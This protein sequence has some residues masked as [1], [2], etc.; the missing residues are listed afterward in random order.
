MWTDNHTAKDFVNFSGVADTVSEII[1]QAQGKPVSIGISGA[2]GMGK[3]SMVEL[4]R[5]SLQTRCEATGVEGKS[6]IVVDFN[7]WLYQGYDDAKAALI[8]VVATRLHEEAETRKTGLDK[9]KELLKRVKWL[10]VGKLTAGAAMSIA[11]GLPPMGL[12]AE[13]FE[14]GKKL[15]SGKDS[16]TGA[17]ISSF[18][19]SATS[20][21]QSL[22]KSK[23]TDS[24][25]K[26]IQQIRDTFAETLEAM[27]VSLVVMID[28]LDR[29]LPETAIS[30]LEAIRLLLFLENTAFVIAADNDMIKN[31]VRKHFDG[32]EEQHIISYFD[33]LIQ[34]PIQVPRLGTQDV[35]AYLLLLYVENS[36][37]DD[38]HKETIRARVCEQL[39]KSWQGKRVDSN[40]VESLGISLPA[41]LRGRLAAADRLA[42]IMTTASSIAGN[43]RLIKRFLNALSIGMS[44]AKGQS[45]S[46]DETHL[47]K[48]LL[49]ERCGPRAA[50][51]ELRNAVNADDEGKARFL[52]ELEQAVRD[53]KE[54]QFTPAWQQDAAFLKE[55][56]KLPPYLA[57][58]DLRAVLYISRDHAPLLSPGDELSSEGAEVLKLLI[59]HP[60]MASRQ[61]DRLKTLQPGD[62]TIIMD[63]LLDKARP[64][65]EWGT[66]QI[67]DAC[68]ALADADSTAAKRFV[69]F[70]IERPVKQIRAGIIPKLQDH[71]WSDEVFKKWVSSD[72]AANVKRA[73]NQTKD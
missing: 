65:Q 51:D 2:W 8:D 29:C 64:I 32:I 30:T 19:A 24:P 36:A 53:G 4:I 59:E 72:V 16:L 11:F 42:P 12:A 49:F 3:S 66:P 27:N 68:I 13:A 17:E 7:A 46:I 58:I 60:T 43:P 5:K 37:L 57:E 33:K 14:M 28:D 69:S 34:V 38:T 47:T 9:A 50:Y 63:K 15:V 52:A 10:R 39:S 21:E 31:A 20:K 35:R 61:Q 56:L 22:L 70:L 73:I 23:P 54:P 71:S 55:W 44:I 6:F 62:S 67:L 26:E 1:F 48:V 25:P 40:F 41:D 45:I 18:F